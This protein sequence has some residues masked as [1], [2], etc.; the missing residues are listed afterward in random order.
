MASGITHERLTY[1]SMAVVL[2][3]GVAWL[4][5]PWVTVAFALLGLWVGGILLS[6]D[7]D[8]ASRPY[9]RWGWFRWLWWPYQRL[10][11]H[12]STLSHHGLWGPLFQ[13]LYLLSLLLGVAYI[14]LQLQKAYGPAESSSGPS[15]QAL[16]LQFIQTHPQECAVLVAGYWASMLLHITTDAFT[17]WWQ[18]SARGLPR[19]KTRFRSSQSISRR[20]SKT[21]P[22]KT[23]KVQHGSDSSDKIAKIHTQSLKPRNARSSANASDK[24]PP[25][26]TE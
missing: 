3:L 15:F 10:V 26:L 20:A 22:K 25:L 4:G 23:A 7:M 1:A 5:L 8:T 6:P 13:G 14:G 11:P 24:G 2:V 16:L 21:A 18:S 12:R 19:H 17:D 9:Y